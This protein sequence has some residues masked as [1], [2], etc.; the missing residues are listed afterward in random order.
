MSPLITLCSSK[1]CKVSVSQPSGFSV[2]QEVDD[3]LVVGSKQPDCVLEEEH[4]GGV[5]HTVGEFI[6]IHLQKR[7][8]WLKTGGQGWGGH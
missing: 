4:E 8:K 5:D 3:A 2:T 1:Q 6:R 7:Q